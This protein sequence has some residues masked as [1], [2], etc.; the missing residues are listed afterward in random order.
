MTVHFDEN[1]KKI[2]Q[3]LRD[4]SDSRMRKRIKESKGGK[5][6][7]MERLQ[8]RREEERKELAEA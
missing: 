4:R 3:T 6:R 1:Y 7:L 8:Q 2:M 5:R